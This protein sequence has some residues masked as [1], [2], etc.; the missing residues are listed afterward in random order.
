MG[1][2]GR[3]VLLRQ[4]LNEQTRDAFI[5]ENESQNIT[6]SG[7]EGENESYNMIPLMQIFIAHKTTLCFVN[8]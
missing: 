4:L 2:A 6:L 5:D 8:E 7:K 3:L 1:A